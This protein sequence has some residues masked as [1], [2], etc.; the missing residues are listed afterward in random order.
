CNHGA[1]AR[2]RVTEAARRI[3][4]AKGEREDQAA[5]H[6]GINPVAGGG[7]PCVAAQNDQP[8]TIVTSA[9]TAAAADA[10]AASEE[11]R[12][13]LQARDRTG[14][15]SGVKTWRRRGEGEPAKT[16]RDSG[17]GRGGR[18]S[19]ARA[20]APDRTTGPRSREA[21]YNSI[22]DSGAQE[23]KDRGELGRRNV[24]SMRRTRRQGGD[25]QVVEGVATANAPAVV[26]EGG[27]DPG[28]GV[29][30]GN[31]GVWEHMEGE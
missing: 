16:R 20:T 26:A 10:T 13:Q 4:R 30:F 6:S 19:A 11:R 1:Q 28:A 21:R 9:A 25:A 29:E 2:E 7:T 14:I 8:A 23:S 3:S 15:G 18:A 27:R 31:S 22:A 17:E 12:R 5:A 24:Q